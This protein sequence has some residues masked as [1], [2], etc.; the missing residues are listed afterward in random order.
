MGAEDG[1]GW[2][3]PHGFDPR[4]S[5]PFAPEEFL[6]EESLGDGAG[7]VTISPLVSENL[8]CLAALQHESGDTLPTDYPAGGDPAAWRRWYA[9]YAS[10]QSLGLEIRYVISANGESV[11][12]CGA[13][14]D[15]AQE[16]SAEIFYWIDARQRRRGYA[17]C[18][19]WALRDELVELWSPRVL[20]AV[21]QFDNQPSRRVLS[22]N[23]FILSA[24]FV[25]DGR[26]GRE[27]RGKMHLEMRYFCR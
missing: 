3:E 2:E 16:D 4:L 12:A 13:M 7:A 1:M 8:P 18:S 15:Q 26:Y 22:K 14:R 24:L 27:A 17:S 25:D 20:S 5:D 11:G 21:V 9:E 10:R 23:R 19:L 6:G